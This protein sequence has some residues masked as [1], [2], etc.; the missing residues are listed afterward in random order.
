MEVNNI[1]EFVPVLS[2]TAINTRQAKKEERSA[3]QPDINDVSMPS[4]AWQKS[5]LLQA[6]DKLE[7]NKQLDDIHPLDR[8]ESSPIDSYEE[9]LIE[10]GFVKNNTSPSDLFGAQANLNPQSILSLFISES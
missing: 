9:A 5:I 6:L 3:R 8:Q 10:L 4:P 1:K 7:N 2:E